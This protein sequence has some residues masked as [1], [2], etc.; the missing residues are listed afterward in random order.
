MATRTAHQRYRYDFLIWVKKFVE[1]PM[2][3]GD[4]TSGRYPLPSYPESIEW[5]N[6]Y[7]SNISRIRRLHAE[8]RVYEKWNPIPSGFTQQEWDDP[9]IILK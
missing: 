2:S 5:A 9:T 7:V 3:Y 4:F 1:D 6:I 8:G